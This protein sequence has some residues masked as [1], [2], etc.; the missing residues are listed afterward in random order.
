MEL[1]DKLK[2][3]AKKQWKWLAVAAVIILAWLV[4]RA[5]SSSD[6]NRKHLYTICRSSTWDSLQLM[7]K[8]RN[9]Q[10][11]IN[12]LMDSVSHESGLRFAWLE[13][14]T[15]TLFERLNS[16]V[17][18]AVISTLKPNV[19]NREQYLFSKPF[20]ELGPVLIVRQDSTA[21]SL[22]D[23]E[24]KTVGISSGASLVF[25]VTRQGVANI[26]NITINSFD[27][28]NRA[29]EALSRD[30]IDG[31]IIDTLRAY[32]YVDGFYAGKLKIITAPLT[33]DGL[34]LIALKNPPSEAL[35]MSFDE[36]LE[37]LKTDGEY[38]AL[39]SRWN[40]INPE[41]QYIKKP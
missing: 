40:L 7:G 17:C 39:L 26:Y 16:G 31:V 11:F 2:I 4:L 30:K 41:V 1:I 27:N 23:M 15:S 12:E 35:I 6:A 22:R 3:F 5:C 21:S 13:T 18:D 25:D 32:H 37:K 20:F 9:L 38:S 14:N 29:L 33:E 34:R 19:V 28:M 10:A 36:T 24:G 8:E